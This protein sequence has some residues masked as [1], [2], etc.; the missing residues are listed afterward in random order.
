MDKELS[1]IFDELNLKVV[2]LE[3]LA[4]ALCAADTS[5]QLFKLDV[6]LENHLGDMRVLIERMEPMVN[7]RGVNQCAGSK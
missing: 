4:S 5:E 2:G 1:T 7:G 6:L 3:G